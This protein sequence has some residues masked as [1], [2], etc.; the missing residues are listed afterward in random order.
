MPVYVFEVLNE[1][2]T[3]YLSNPQN[4]VYESKFSTILCSKESELDWESLSKQV[5]LEYLGFEVPFENITVTK[6][7]SS[8]YRQKLWV[9]YFKVTITLNSRFIQNE[10]KSSGVEY[11]W[12]PILVGV[13]RYCPME[14]WC[15]CKGD[16]YYVEAITKE[17]KLKEDSVRKRNGIGSSFNIKF[18]GKR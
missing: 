16:G 15:E 14:W 7:E 17:E 3:E 18:A 6:L 11:V 9:D 2:Q 12:K 1:R 8:M 4:P 10:Y 13:Q 5:C